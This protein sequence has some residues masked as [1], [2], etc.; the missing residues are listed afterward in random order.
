[1]TL[2][3]FK[4]LE[5]SQDGCAV[6]SKQVKLVVDHDHSTN[7]IRGLLCS[8][9]NTGLGMFKDS[10]EL[11]EKASNYLRNSGRGD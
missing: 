6:C 3:E 2:Q 11:L 9:C 1:M 5:S 7:E 4:A 8:N 10:T